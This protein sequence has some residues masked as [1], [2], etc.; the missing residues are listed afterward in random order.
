VPNLATCFDRAGIKFTS[1]E[2]NEIHKAIE[3]VPIT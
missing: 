3:K 2:M 1:E